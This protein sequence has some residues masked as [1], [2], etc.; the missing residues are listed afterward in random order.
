MKLSRTLDKVSDMY[1]LN[2]TEIGKLSRILTSLIKGSLDSPN[3]CSPVVDKLGEAKILEGWDSVFNNN[4]TKINDTLNSIEQNER[5]KFGSRSRAKPWSDIKEEFYEY[6][7]NTDTP[8]NMLPLPIPSN[9][10]NRLRPW[11][12]KKVV[13]TI[14]NSTSAGL[15]Y[16]V[17]KGLVKDRFLDEAYLMSE[18]LKQYAA[19]PFVRTQEMLKTRIVWGIAIANIIY[20]GRFFYPFLEYQKKQSWR[21]ALLGPDAVDKVVTEMVIKAV[22]QGEILVSMDFSAYDRSLGP[23]LQR[24]YDYYK[25]EVFQKQFCDIINDIGFRRV[26]VPMVTPDGLKTGPHG[27]PSGSADTNEAGSVI[28]ATI[29]NDTGLV[30]LGGDSSQFHGDDS[31]VRLPGE[32]EVNTYIASFKRR[33]LDVN[34]SK[35][36]KAENFVVF[37]QRLYHIDYIDEGKLG[38]I[39]STYRA[40]NR[41]YNY[42]RFTDFLDYGLDGKDFNSIRTISILENCIF[43]PLFEDLVTYVWSLDKYN[44]EF[45][46]TGLRK[47][48]EMVRETE[49]TDGLIRNQYGTEVSGIKSFKSY[50][51]ISQLNQS[52]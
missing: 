52:E 24:Y 30:E 12:I 9:E 45:S 41:I 1:N 44:L 50:K 4:K 35:T 51:L 11:E 17:K 5:E 22:A 29:A 13:D 39:Y 46:D 49:G 48:V 16:L 10:R 31:V 37:L 23:V 27:L 43:S 40:L 7:D 20:E 3:I 14:K 2:T 34:D 42:E 26:N 36:F 33:G 25:C 8:D 19:V 18:W 32:E 47:Y 38:G 15:P 6:W 21:V 28:Q